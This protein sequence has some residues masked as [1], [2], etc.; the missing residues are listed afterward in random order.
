M[1]IQHMLSLKWRMQKK[2][3]QNYCKYSTGK[4]FEKKILE[5]VD[6]KYVAFQRKH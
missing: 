6:R 3:K 1:L 4:L 5:S 2:I